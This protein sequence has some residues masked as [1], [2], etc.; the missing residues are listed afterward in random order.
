MI[1]FSLVWLRVA[2][3]LV[4]LFVI[5]RGIR[6]KQGLKIRH[7]VSASILLM[8]KPISHIAVPLTGDKSDLLTFFFLWALKKKKKKEEEAQPPCLMTLNKL[9]EKAMVQCLPYFTHVL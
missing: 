7:S 5:S 8:S 6:Y 4:S 1:D 9:Q 3:Q 2:Q